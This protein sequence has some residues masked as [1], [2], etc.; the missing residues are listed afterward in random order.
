MG[1]DLS[2]GPLDWKRRRLAVE[3]LPNNPLEGK[4]GRKEPIDTIQ[5]STWNVAGLATSNEEKWKV[6][7][8]RR[9]PRC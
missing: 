1:K 6:R 9:L 2:D 8:C 7:T 5:M 4:L 3:P